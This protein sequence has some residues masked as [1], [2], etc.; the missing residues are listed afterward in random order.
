MER[1]ALLLLKQK[2]VLGRVNLWMH[3]VT[4]CCSKFTETSGIAFGCGRTASGVERAL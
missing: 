2:G 3:A 1:F 4:K